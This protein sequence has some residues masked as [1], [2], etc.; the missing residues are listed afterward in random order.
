M[1]G[2]TP[3]AALCLS[4]TLLAGCPVTGT[5]AEFLLKD[6]ETA[7][8][9]PMAF[10]WFAGKRRGEQTA[11]LSSPGCPSLEF[12][13]D[14]Y[15]D[16]GVSIE[17]V[18]VHHSRKARAKTL[19]A[20][21]RTLTGFHR[22]FP[23]LGSPEIIMVDRENGSIA[24]ALDQGNEGRGYI[25]M[26]WKAAHVLDEDQ[27]AATL[28]HELGHIVLK[29]VASSW[30]DRIAEL[31]LEG[32]PTPHVT[33][34]VQGKSPI[35]RRRDIEHDA[36]LIGKRILV[37]A[38][39]DAD[40]AFTSLFEQM[41]MWGPVPEGDPEYPTNPSRI[42]RLKAASFDPRNGYNLMEE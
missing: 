32:D 27:L 4:L 8:L 30:W 18:L 13:K 15:K 34:L 38:G 3:I 19:R 37:A 7:N 10:D 22:L 28:A 33:A 11:K 2:R 39:M 35:P 25:F 36:D 17:C 1:P 26:H 24:Q 21:D 42:A 20:Y 40:K 5:C 9:R 23:T 12:V 29:N 6:L 16:K 14:G 41:E 31:E